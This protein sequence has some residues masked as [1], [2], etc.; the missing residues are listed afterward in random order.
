LQHE[1][2]EGKRPIIPTYVPKLI[3]ELI[4]KCLSSQPKERPTS[5][6]IYE[7]INICI[8]C[9]SS[10]PEEK[11]TSKEIYE[12]INIWSNKILN[13]E[14]TEFIVQVERADEM[15]FNNLE[16]KLSKSEEIYVSERHT[17]LNV[18]NFNKSNC[19]DSKNS[20]SSQSLLIIEQFRSNLINIT[21][22]TGHPICHQNPANIGNSNRI[23][24]LSKNEMNSESLII[25]QL[26]HNQ[27][28]IN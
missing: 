20:R 23:F 17:P 26:L 4:N 9:L 8:K 10:Q 2:C 6:N 15:T 19:I 1:I 11:P 21:K 22:N 27:S 5:K 7:T 25:D 3:A 12:I 24:A 13:T 18:I 14:P 16:S 28:Q